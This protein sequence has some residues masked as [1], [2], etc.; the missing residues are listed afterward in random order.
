MQRDVDR[1]APQRVWERFAT[2]EPTLRPLPEPAFEA[3]RLQPLSVNRSALR[4]SRRRYRLQPERA[5]S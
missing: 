2:E 5:E 1:L 3:R 4:A